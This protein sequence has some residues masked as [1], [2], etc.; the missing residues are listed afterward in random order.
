M[1]KTVYYITIFI[2]F[3]IVAFAVYAVVW[4]VTLPFDKNKEISHHYSRMWSR[5]IYGIS[6]WWKIKVEGMEHVKKGHSYVVVSNHQSML[7]IPLLYQLP[8]NFKWVSKQEVFRIPIFGWVLWM[9]DD[10]AIKRGG[11]SSAKGMVDKADKMLKRG[12]S[13]VI[14]PEGTRTKTGRVNEFKPGTFIMA[15]RSKV[16]ILP[17][18]IDGTFNAFKGKDNGKFAIAAPHTFTVKVLPPIPVEAIEDMRFDELSEKLQSHIEKEHRTIAPEYY[19][20]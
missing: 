4:L 20:E 13:V 14:F 10:I 1:M 15:K 7:D 12:V 19:Q 6:P 16:E 3:S 2:L 11:A 18:V 8:F 9:H 5:G 17:V